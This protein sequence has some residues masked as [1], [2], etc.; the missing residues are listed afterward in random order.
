[1]RVLVIYIQF[2]DCCIHGGSLSSYACN[3]CWFTLTKN[4]LYKIRI[5]L[6]RKQCNIKVRISTKSVSKN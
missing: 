5:L 3:T 1:M 2:K 6:L 4:N